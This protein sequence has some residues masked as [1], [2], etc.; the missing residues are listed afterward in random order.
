[1]ST[2][3]WVGGT[4]GD[5]ADA[6]DWSGGAVPQTGDDVI[7]GDG[8]TVTVDTAG[9]AADDITLGT[10]STLYLTTTLDLGGTLSG[11]VLNMVEAGDLVGGTLDAPLVDVPYVGHV[12][13]LDGVDVVETRP[14]GGITI[15]PATS[16]A[17]AAQPLLVSGGLSLAGGTYD[18]SFVADLTVGG[19]L[20]GPPFMVADA[21]VTLGPQSSI[22][23]VDAGVEYDLFDQSPVSS[24]TTITNQGTI[25][26][27]GG[28]VSESPPGEI[29]TEISTTA[30]VNTGT[31]TITPG[32]NDGTVPISLY[33]SS[34]VFDNSG[35]I[36][37]DGG[38][39]NLI[40][41]TFDNTGTIGLP[42]ISPPASS[43]TSVFV[44]ADISDFTNTGTIIGSITF[45]DTVSP[46]ALT[47]L[48]G[49]VTIQGEL[50]LDGGTLPATAAGSSLTITGVLNLDG[51]TL[52]AGAF[53]SSLTITG[54]VENGTLT[55]N[56]GT[57]SL[58]GAT[59]LNTTVV[60]S[61]N[62]TASGI[63][64]AGSVTPANLTGLRGPVT[65]EG[66]LNLDGGTLDAGAFG[67]SLTIAGEVEDG[68]LTA[69]AGTLVLDG[70]VLLDTNV[71]PGSNVVANGPIT[72]IDPPPS[73]GLTLDG[74]TDNIE[75]AGGTTIVTLA[76]T[77]SGT[78]P[79]LA[80]S[81]AV[82][83]SGGGTISQ[84][85]GTVSVVGA[86]PTSAIDDATI[87]MA[88]GALYLQT[89]LTGDYQIS[90]GTDATAELGTVSG[91]GTITLADDASVTIDT[92]AASGS[93]TIAFTGSSD[94]V[95]LP[96]V[97]TGLTLQGMQA[98]D[99]IDLSGLSFA[100]TGEPSAELVGGTLDI[101]TASG[102]TAG[103]PFA[104]ASSDTGFIVLSDG[105]DGTMVGLPPLPPLTAATDFYDTAGTS[106][107]TVALD[108][109][110]LSEGSIDVEGAYTVALLAGAV[111]QI[112][113]IYVGQAYNAAAPPY[114]YTQGAGGI[115]IVGDGPNS[116]TLNVTGDISLGDNS[117]FY[118]DN[119]AGS[120]VL[121]A[122]GGISIVA[123]SMSLQYGSVSVDAISSVVLGQAA[124]TLGALTVAAGA[125]LERH[126]FGSR[127]Q[128]YRRRQYK[129]RRRTG[130]SGRP[131]R[132]L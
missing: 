121:S 117:G 51:G 90:L 86:G 46:A 127:R 85:S 35:V 107:P 44:S 5:W 65:I 12:G 125:S 130:I 126:Q 132:L 25:V 58:D 110:T 92:L 72:V 82:T 48:Q 113:T 33:V 7:V 47:G 10:G 55:A 45:D 36:S 98:G 59:L 6:A 53:G 74:V 114:Q 119:D 106:N 77:S 100:G 49:A 27:G 129:S 111:W 105:G 80:A 123:A 73:V 91:D 76:V 102:A 39:I 38:T 64:I 20:Y 40:G 29:A 71:T 34:T 78:A 28:P 62:V 8:I 9:V 99:F 63:I 66:T 13:T 89:P 84:G 16:V 69:N 112:G 37:D 30:F 15:T 81:G 14:I 104:G 75:I 50:D 11:G 1:M 108:G 31:I 94:V 17:S 21:N 22:T 67:S 19:D 56:T 96:G 87:S 54:T 101:A 95:V 128:P 24:T 131:T 68:T 43:T 18:G 57:L 118:Y 23:L 120:G 41:A 88:A 60:Q 122:S 115:A 124:A 103:I 3:T 70:S 4:S 83:L 32:T 61:S 93:L 26:L 2:V 79:I 97:G 52:D 109:T 42:A 116:G